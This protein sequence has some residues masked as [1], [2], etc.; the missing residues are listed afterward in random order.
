MEVEAPR[1]FKVTRGFVVLVSNQ[2]FES[3]ID[4]V[5]EG[6]IG[7]IDSR[8][9]LF[10]PK[11]A[12]IQN[13]NSYYFKGIERLNV[14]SQIKSCNSALGKTIFSLLYRE[15]YFK[16]NVLPS[17]IIAKLINLQRETFSRNLTLLKKK[18]WISYAKCVCFSEIEIVDAEAMKQHLI[19]LL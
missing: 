6:E 19:K 18:G 8:V 11:D 7:L 12:E 2:D 10:C 17:Y 15:Q 16:S 9:A 14:I 13:N 3:L 4:L 5:V 1:I